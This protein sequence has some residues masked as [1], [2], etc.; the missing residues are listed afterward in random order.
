[1]NPVINFLLAVFVVLGCTV[2][3]GCKT[4]SSSEVAEPTVNLEVGLPIEELVAQLGEPALVKPMENEREGFEVWVYQ[5]ETT[6]LEMLP[7]TTVSRPYINPITGEMLY[8]EEPVYEAVDKVKSATLEV[9][10]SR[11]MVVAWK[12]S[13]DVDYEF[14][15]N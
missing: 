1:M 9:L 10:V 4:T 11:E 5:F 3:T 6:D 12:T 8:E 14:S 13:Q 15:K 7:T 2:F